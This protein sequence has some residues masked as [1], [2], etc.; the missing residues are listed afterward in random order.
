M[1][2][3]LATPWTLRM[4]STRYPSYGSA[5]VSYNYYTRATGKGI[6]VY[7][8]DTGVI[9]G[10]QFASKII[11]GPI[12]TNSSVAGSHGTTIASMLLD[13]WAGVCP[14][15]MVVDVKVMEWDGSGDVPT[16]I[17]GLEWVYYNAVIGKSV[18]NLSLT[19]RRSD[20]LDMAV[21]TVFQRGIPLFAAAGNYGDDSCLYSP[22]ASPGAYSIGSASHRYGVMDYSN[23]GKCVNAFAPGNNVPAAW[24]SS[25]WNMVD[26]SSGAVAFATAVAA[27]MLSD[28]ELTDKSPTAIYTRMTNSATRYQLHMRASLEGTP[29]MLLHA[30]YMSDGRGPWHPTPE[31]TPDG[32]Y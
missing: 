27:M 3:R 17:R 6:N 28:P 8:L 24:G 18:V 10:T 7:L 26:G 21:H 19:T 20:A 14:E 2:A 4:I 25:Q 1:T 16:I 29:N 22:A 11:K 9:P 12:F 13:P 5:L 30:L 23:T 32:V 31:N 15:C